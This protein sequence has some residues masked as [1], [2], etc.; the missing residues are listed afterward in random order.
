MSARY[1]LV[2]RSKYQPTL[3]GGAGAFQGPDA[4]AARTDSYRLRADQLDQPIDFLTTCPTTDAEVDLTNAR[5]ELFP[6]ESPRGVLHAKAFEAR[7]TTFT[8]DGTAEFALYFYDMSEQV[9]RQIPGSRVKFDVTGTGRLNEEDSPTVDAVITPKRFLYF[10]QLYVGGDF[11][12]AGASR[13][14]A[15]VWHISTQTKLEKIY[16]RVSMTN[17]GNLDMVSAT[18]LSSVARNIAG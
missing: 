6:I 12:I 8:A 3:P 7:C 18:Y 13:V 4:N 10:G 15:R 5:V 1:L 11:L 9:F 2:D 16:P 14:N 17:T